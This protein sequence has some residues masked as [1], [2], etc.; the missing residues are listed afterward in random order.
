MAAS[1]QHAALRRGVHGLHHGQCRP[2]G[3]LR[4]RRRVP[5]AARR[6]PANTWV[7]LFATT[8]VILSAAYAL[9]L[10]RR[11]AFGVLDKKEVAAMPDLSTREIAVL[12]PLLLLTIWYGVKPGQILD[13]CA[14]SVSL[15]IKNYDAALT[16]TKT[17]ALALQ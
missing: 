2:A 3:H 14:A 4:L 13:A 8:G 6:L 11:I 15:L 10:Y 1:S 7:A 12:A 17:A 5:D 16:A 9:Y